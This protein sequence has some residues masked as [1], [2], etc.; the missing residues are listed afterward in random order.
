MKRLLLNGGMW[1][2]NDLALKQTTT[3]ERRETSER[4]RQ[5]SSTSFTLDT[6][7]PDVEGALLEALSTGDCEAAAVA[8]AMGVDPNLQNP[9]GDSALMLASDGGHSEL[10]ELLV[11]NGADVNMPGKGRRSALFAAAAV[12]SRRRAA[13]PP[14]ERR[15]RQCY[16]RGRQDSSL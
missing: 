2:V 5:E 14:G 15:A 3:S 11:S 1:Q 7:D 6:D 8:L 13:H 4:R 9:S 12:R 16:R 10:I